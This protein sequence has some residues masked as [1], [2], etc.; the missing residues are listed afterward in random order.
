MIRIVS[1]LPGATELVFELGLGDAL[2][3]VS[4]E[5][6]L[7]A[8]ADP[9]PVVV[10]PAL[11][12]SSKTARQVD[13]AVSRRRDREGHL[14]YVD[15]ERLRSLDPDLLL[16]QDLCEVCAPS[17]DQI[18]RVVQSM[19]PPPRTHSM[20]PTDLEGI[21]RDVV[22]LGAKAGVE[23]R[24]RAWTD[25]A[26]ERLSDLRTALRGVSPR[27]RVFCMEWLDPPFYAGHW[28][29]QQVELAGGKDGLAPPGEA[30][31][32]LS[33]RRI[34]RYDPEW[35]LLM[36]CGYTTRQV[37]DE[38]DRLVEYEGYRRLTAVR[39]GNVYAVNAEA[40]F[41]RPGPGVIEGTRL[42]AH[43]FHPE[44]VSWEGPSEAFQR[45]EL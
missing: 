21:L 9:R 23:G 11:D 24:A 6:R 2:V 34:R 36:P 29:P 31:G 19:D 20:T 16:T 39:R 12:L 5:C 40:Y 44:R 43:L 35:L 1:L 13:E 26:R 38:A 28:V 32:R 33:W 37:V 4:H 42:L 14:Y 10:Q 22:E 15:E 3:G 25:R 17:G 45:L 8:G 7:P 41:A 27:T 18:D 30:S